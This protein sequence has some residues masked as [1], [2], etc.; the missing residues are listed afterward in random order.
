M[1]LH[2]H[3]S[4]RVVLA[5][6]LLGLCRSAPAFADS[7]GYF[8]IGPDYLAYETRF[9]QGKT[10]HLLHVVRFNPD[11]G[12]VVGSPVALEDFQVHDMTCRSG[13]VDVEG[14]AEGFSVAIDG[15]NLSPAAARTTR[16]TPE[17][18][19]A[20]KNLGLW[21]KEAM[22]DLPG[23]GFPEEFQLVISRTSRNVR[24]AVEHYTITHLIRRDPMRP[25]GEQIVESLKIFEGIFRET[26]D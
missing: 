1:A 16:F 15:S 20:L 12:F 11:S 19:S 14:F 17:N 13:F 8:C 25:I 21:A 22:I 5:L 3:F 24:Q 7:D 18:P 26:V 9:S 4:T 23:G 10:G 2:R 6:A